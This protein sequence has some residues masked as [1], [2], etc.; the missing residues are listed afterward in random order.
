MLINAFIRSAITRRVHRALLLAH[1][2]YV[3]KLMGLDVGRGTVIHPGSR[4]YHCDR[5]LILGRNCEIHPGAILAPYGGKIRIGNHVTVNPFS[6]LY[7]HGGLWIGDGVRIA[8]HVVIVPANHSIAR[9]I[10]IRSQPLTKKGIRIEDDVWVGAGAKILDG[11][12]IARGCVIAAGAVLTGTQTEP[13]TIYGGIPAKQ[14][15][16]R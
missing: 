11:S 14:I 6:V 10:P 2:F 9:D 4:I 1:T 13:Y 7:G 15:G 3:A 5:D 16:T 8:A 12:Q